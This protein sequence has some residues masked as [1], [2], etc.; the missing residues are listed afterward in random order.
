MNGSLA[1]ALVPLLIAA[2]AGGGW[3]AWQGWRARQALNRLEEVVKSS[4]LDELLHNP[5][6]GL[7]EAI[8]LAVRGV[9]L[10]QGEAGHES[11]TLDADWATLRQETGLV[12]VNSP[13][14]R[15][16]LGDPGKSPPR[17]VEVR[18][19]SGRLEENNTLLTMEGSV[20]AEY[21]DEV[22]TGPVATFRNDARVLVFPDGASLDG[23]TLAG[24]AG[25]LRWNLAT[26][27]LDGEGGVDVVWTPRSAKTRPSAP[28]PGEEGEAA[29]G[30]TP[31]PEPSP[32]KP[33]PAHARMETTR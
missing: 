3:L 26:N 27:I 5:P 19:E 21:Q 31:P 23:P 12:Q 33:G 10:S 14:V 1:R 28:A 25:I 2:L 18:S 29:P 15:Y 24:S 20:R 32:A 13:F 7:K 30:G 8:D 9:R 16:A 4:D 22:L 17:Q 6:D 11:W